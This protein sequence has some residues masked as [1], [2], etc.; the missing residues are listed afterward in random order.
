MTYHKFSCSEH[1]KIKHLFKFFYIFQSFGDRPAN[2]TKI[3]LFILIKKRHN[4]SLIGP[5][6]DRDPS[7]QV[8]RTPLASL[9]I[10]IALRADIF[11]TN[12]GFSEFI[13]DKSFS[14]TH[15]SSISYIYKLKPTFLFDKF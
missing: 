13:R 2:E 6:L 3:F 9:A 4:S 10:S 14:P 1:N 7:V 15:M 5:S 12:Q 11:P 8:I